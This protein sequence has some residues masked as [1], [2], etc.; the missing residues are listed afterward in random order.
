MDTSLKGKVIF[1]SASTDGLGLAIASKAVREGAHVF[2]G[3]RTK[4][5]LEE[6]VGN[7][8]QLAKGSGGKV[9]GAV[10][11]MASADSIQAWVGEGEKEFGEPWGLLVNAGGPPP[12]DFESFADDKAWYAAFE[13]T[14][15]SSVRLIRAVLPSIKKQGGSIL[16]ITSSSV[17]E[18]W[19]GLILSGVMR[20]GVASLVKSLS[21][22]LAPSG[23]RVNNIAPGNIATGRLDRLIASEAAQKGIKPEEQRAVRQAAIPLG[24][25]GE[26]GEFG[27]VGAFLLSPA[28]SY[29][30]GQ[31]ILVDGGATKFLY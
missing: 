14:L 13:L 8:S 27:A 15:M 17:K 5:R 12:G 6:A 24:R 10:L 20:S 4:T 28:A 18:P 21:I 29:V 9:G 7:L 22:E 25:I 16:T 2:L 26:V 1:A 31:T 30:T 19:P 3:G 23:V 11:D